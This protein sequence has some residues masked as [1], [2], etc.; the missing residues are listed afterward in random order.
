MNFA[1]VLKEIGRGSKGSR[2]L[3]AEE[4]HQLFGAILDGGVPELELGGILMALRVK[5]ESVS[6]LLGFSQAVSERL[7]RLQLPAGELR[8]VVIGSYNGARRQPNLMPLIALLL[9]R[10]RVPVLVH[11]QLEGHGRVASAYVF[12][13]LGMLPCATL[14]QAQGTLDQDGLAFV[15]IAVLAPGLANLLA[16]RSRLGV[17]NSGHSMA[18]LIDPFGGGALKLVSV[19]HPEVLVKTREYFLASGDT[20]LLMRGTEGEPYANPRRRPK[21]E[22]F[23]DGA[24]QVL[25]EQEHTPGEQLVETAPNTEARATAD[26]IRGVMAGRASVPLPIVNQLACC[27]YGAGY[28]SDFN[29]AKAIVAVETRSLAAA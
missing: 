29:K 24:S 2:D 14:A 13:E 16:L 25:F 3:G 18:K 17:R 28:T 1:Q 9:Q 5:T 19:T 11:G 4:A 12:R 20:A 27:L 10:M 23:S 26:Y 6:E 22:Y 8:P 15:P 21:I 7:Y